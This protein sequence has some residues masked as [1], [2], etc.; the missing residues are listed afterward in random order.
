MVSL[1]KRCIAEFIGTFFL[2]FFG[3]GSAA[4]T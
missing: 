2:V 3:A 4:I 1:T